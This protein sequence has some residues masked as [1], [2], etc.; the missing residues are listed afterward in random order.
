MYRQFNDRGSLA[1]QGIS[2]I[3]DM[4]HN[5]TASYNT[6]SENVG[7]VHHLS[8]H[9]D[10]LVRECRRLKERKGMSYAAISRLT[11]IPWATVRCWCVYR[12]RLDA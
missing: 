7:A 8:E 9:P 6:K 11:G 3:L 1:L 2:D 5:Q 4:G 12:T 10:S